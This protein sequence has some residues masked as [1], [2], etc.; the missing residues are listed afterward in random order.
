MPLERLINNCLD[1][2]RMSFGDFIKVFD[3]IDVCHFVN[4][5]FFSIKKTWTETMLHGEWTTGSRGSERDR[6]GGNAENGTFLYNPQVSGPSIPKNVIECIK[7][8]VLLLLH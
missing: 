4:T 8:S 7:K 1:H 6:A 2:F 5:S 3:S